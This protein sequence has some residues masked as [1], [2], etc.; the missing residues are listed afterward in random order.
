MRSDQ[1]WR[2]KEDMGVVPFVVTSTGK[3]VLFS[4]LLY[5]MEMREFKRGG[6]NDE[7]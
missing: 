6:E 4:V 3:G 5:Q 1:W 7:K 2:M